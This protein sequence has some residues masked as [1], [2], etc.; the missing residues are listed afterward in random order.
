VKKLIQS[1]LL[2]H[3]SALLL[4]PINLIQ[5]SHAVEQDLFKED[6]FSFQLVING[7]LLTANQFVTET[8]QLDA[9]KEELQKDQEEI[10]LKE[11][12]LTNHNKQLF[13]LEFSQEMEPPTLCQTHMLLLSEKV[14]RL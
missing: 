9:R 4:V 1:P 6:L 14:K 12:G 3:H 10:D 7:S 2:L 13:K 5:V 11:N 8:L